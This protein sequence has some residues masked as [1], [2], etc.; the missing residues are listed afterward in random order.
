MQQAIM[1]NARTENGLNSISWMPQMIAFS[2][3]IK[4]RRKR[5]QTIPLIRSKLANAP[6]MYMQ[7]SAITIIR[8]GAKVKPCVETIRTICAT[9]D[10]LE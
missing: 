10:M 1:N 4:A 8:G 7:Q 6:T 3:A 5:F 2:N 9:I